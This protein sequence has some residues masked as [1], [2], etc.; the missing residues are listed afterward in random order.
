M[1]VLA[2]LDGVIDDGN[3]A[4]VT[5]HI[6]VGDCKA[7]LCLGLLTGEGSIAE[8]LRVLGNTVCILEEEICVADC[9]IILFA[10]KTICFA[11]CGIAGDVGAQGTCIIEVIGA[12]T[13]S[14]LVG[15]EV[16]CDRFKYI[17]THLAVEVGDEAVRKIVVGRCE[18]LVG[19]L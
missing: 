15:D 18:D 10:A 6:C 13:F 5:D 14:V 19:I 9:V 4:D 16:V 3:T 1:H 17:L 8:I 12:V 11:A 7:H 2:G